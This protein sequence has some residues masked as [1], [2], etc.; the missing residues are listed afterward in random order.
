MNPIR[1]ENPKQ[2][3]SKL[4]DAIDAVDLGIRRYLLRHLA[5]WHPISTAPH[6]QDLEIR[7]LDENGLV[8][9][10]FPCL[11]T[12]ASDW[13]NTDLGTRVY[14]VRWRIWQKAKS[15]QPHRLMRVNSCFRGDLN[16]VDQNLYSSRSVDAYSRD[17]PFS[18]RG[19]VGGCATLST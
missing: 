3:A 11:R 19:D 2:M 5:H 1:K 16:E 4:S 12:N 14:R 8:A 10:P 13:I 17:R 7:T 6:N 9:I 18:D 15:P